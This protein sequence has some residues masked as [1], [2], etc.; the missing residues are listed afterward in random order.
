MEEVSDEALMKK[1]PHKSSKDI[2]G[3]GKV[4]KAGISAKFSGLQ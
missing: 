3:E 1:K 4:A 2:K